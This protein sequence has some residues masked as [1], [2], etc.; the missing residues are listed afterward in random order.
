MVAT[1]FMDLSKAFDCLP[2]GLII[3]KIHANGFSLYACDLFSS[4]LCNR[5]QR[6]EVKARSEW[7]VIKKGIPQGSILG[8]LLFNVSVDN[9]IHFMENVRFIIMAMI[10]LYLWHPVI[11]MTFCHI[12][13]EIVRMLLN[14]SGTMECKLIRSSSSL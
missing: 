3:A 11:Y 8:P 7:V 4:Y 6:A 2:N 13:A 5:L 10:I 12:S 1:V 14:G 9:M